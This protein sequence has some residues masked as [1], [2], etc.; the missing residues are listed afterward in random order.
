MPTGQMSEGRLVLSFAILETGEIE[1]GD[2]AVFEQGGALVACE[3]G[4]SIRQCLGPLIVGIEEG[5][6]AHQDQNFDIAQWLG[7]GV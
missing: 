2:N 4:D 5:N 1:T 3:L 7:D 6:A